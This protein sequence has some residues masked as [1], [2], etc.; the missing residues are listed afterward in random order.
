VLSHEFNSVEGWEL[1]NLF[2]V[3]RLMLAAMLARHESR[4]V[5][6]RSDYPERDNDHFAKRLI[7]S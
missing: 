5:H 3:A 7:S 1:Q 4:G 6:F 2:T